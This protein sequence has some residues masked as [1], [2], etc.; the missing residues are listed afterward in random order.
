MGGRQSKQL[1]KE[2]AELKSH[3]A[4]E[5]LKHA[6]ELEGVKRDKRELEFKLGVLQE[7]VCV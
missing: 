7:L 5:K 4:L 1:K 3:S 2:L 6:E